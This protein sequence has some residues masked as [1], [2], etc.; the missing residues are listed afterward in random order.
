MA[1]SS[2]LALNTDVLTAICEAIYHTRDVDR[3]RHYNRGMLRGFS[4]TCKAIRAASVPILFRVLKIRRESLEVSTHILHE[5]LRSGLAPHIRQFSFSPNIPVQILGQYFRSRDPS[6]L[7]KTP[8]DLPNC[9]S[10]FVEILKAMPS[11]EYLNFNPNPNFGAPLVEAFYCAFVVQDPPVRMENVKWLAIRSGDT[12]LRAA[13]PNVTSLTVRMSYDM[14]LDDPEVWRAGASMVEELSVAEL[15][16]ARGRENVIHDI[17]VGMSNVKELSLQ[18][19]PGGNMTLEAELP[20]FKSLRSLVR[21]NLPDAPQLD[22]DFNPPWCGNAY[23]DYSPEELQQ[24]LQR[25]RDQAN[26]VC[27][28]A[29][30]AVR[31]VFPRIQKVQIGEDLWDLTKLQSTSEDE[32]DNLEKE[33]GRFHMKPVFRYD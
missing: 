22:Q 11:L 12:Y 10:A 3:A 30:R 9:A 28:R 21:I 19:P 6:V 14:G 17:C 20:H 2:L 26:A 31:A 27:A 8:D 4:T 23:D 25:Q 33:E 18:T 15:H 1:P 13:C 5:L 32:F 29:R 16:V 24:V 7:F